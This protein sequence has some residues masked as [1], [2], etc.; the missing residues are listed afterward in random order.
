MDNNLNVLV[1]AKKEL[2]N[3]LS[4]TILPSALDCMDSLYAESKVETQGRNT[5]KAF[6]EKLAKIPQWNNYQIDSEVGK[7]VDRCGGCLDEMTAACFV[8]TVKIISSVRL[9]K[10][11]RKV[12]LKIPTNDVFVLGVYTNVAKRIYED[13]YIYQEVVSRNDRRK[14]LLKRMDGVVEETVK[15]MLPINQILKTYLNKNAVDVMNGEP[16]EPEP[17]SEADPESD[18]FPG[19]GELPVEDESEMPEEPMEP[20]E[21]MEPAEPSEP[22]LPMSEEPVDVPQ[23]ETKSFTFNDK[24]MRRAPMPPMD[25]E[26]DFSINPSANR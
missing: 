9:S 17:E 10:D 8:A 14:D 21:P 7:C 2:L 22:S 25:E 15:E 23:E 24:I 13:P 20:M 12:S 5:L 18:M 6:Q 26:A 19:G 16:I 4:S 1:E 3:Q 11:S